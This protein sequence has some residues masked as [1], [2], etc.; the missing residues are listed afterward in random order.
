MTPSEKNTECIVQFPLADLRESE[1]FKN[2]MPERTPKEQAELNADVAANGVL[3]PID[4]W[5]GENV[6]IDGYGRTEAARSA[7]SPTIPVVFRDFENEEAAERLAVIKNLRRRHLTEADRLRLV[8]K[9]Y[10]APA[11][12]PEQPRESGRF[13]V[14]PNGGNGGRQ[15]AEIA[16]FSRA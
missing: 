3:E 8:R 1:R 6:I 2:L 11:E 7:A 14:P 9:L 4:V 12:H 13:T 16:K 5:R 10:A 15:S